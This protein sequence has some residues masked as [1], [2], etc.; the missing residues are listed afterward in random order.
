MSFGHLK[1][2]ACKQ[3]H[4]WTR[5][6]L[7]ASEEN[8]ECLWIINV[9]LKNDWGKISSSRDDDLISCSVVSLGQSGMSWVLQALLCSNANPLQACGTRRNQNQEW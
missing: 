4:S 6:R 3:S 7:K 1:E 9:Y 2:S 8:Q 5:T